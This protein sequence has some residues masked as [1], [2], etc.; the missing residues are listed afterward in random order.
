MSGN[1][2][3]EGAPLFF[4]IWGIPFVAIGLYIVF[5]RFLV[6]ARVRARTVYGVSNERILIVGGLFSRQTRSLPLRTLSDISLTERADGSGTIT[7]G[8]QPRW[9]GR[10][11]SG[12]PTAG[13]T[14]APA[15]E[16]IERA[17]EVHE[18]IRKV[19]AASK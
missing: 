19:Q 4:I 14:S 10:L 16:M 17:R 11:P 3:K 1:I 12:W 9:P 2:G 8:S 13:Q 5:G 6:D 15:F 7:F 18:I